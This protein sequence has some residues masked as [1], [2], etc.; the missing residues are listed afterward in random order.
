M[1]RWWLEGAHEGM[2]ELMMSCVA[3]KT[4]LGLFT[5]NTRPCT[6][7]CCAHMLCISGVLLYCPMKCNNWGWS[8]WAAKCSR[9]VSWILQYLHRNWC[10]LWFSLSFTSS[11]HS[12]PLRPHSFAYLHKALLVFLIFISI[13]R[14]D[15]LWLILTSRLCLPFISALMTPFHHEAAPP[16]CLIALWL[17]LSLLLDLPLTL[18]FTYKNPCSLA[19]IS[20]V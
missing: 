3:S 11:L 15:S 1:D 10:L 18:P 8:L 7:G 20:S 2:L 16:L 13:H 14:Y 19:S 9:L 12:I 4:S 6:K 5:C 17:V